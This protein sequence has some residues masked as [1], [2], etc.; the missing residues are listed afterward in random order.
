MKNA[1]N[2]FTEHGTPHLLT[3]SERLAQTTFGHTLAAKGI[4]TAR[5]EDLDAIHEQAEAFAKA[6]F[7]HPF[8]PTTQPQDLLRKHQFEQHHKDL[9]ERAIPASE[10]SDAR[11]REIEHALAHENKGLHKPEVPPL[12]VGFAV[13]MIALT[14]APTL[15]DQFFTTLNDSV[16]A[17][18]ASTMASSVLGAFV[19]WS[20]LG[21][22][23]LGEHRSALNWTGLLA[24]VGI[25]LGLGVLRIAY[26]T[27]SGEYIFAAALTL[28]EISTVV[29]VEFI[30]SGLRSRHH[31]WSEQQS[32]LAPL[33]A[34]LEAAKRNQVHCHTHQQQL[35]QHCHDHI[36]YVEFR[37]LRHDKRDSIHL[38]A[39]AV[40]ESGYR[41]QLAENHRIRTGNHHPNLRRVA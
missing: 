37:Q 35:E 24:G 41:E 27:T 1:T 4:D 12:I 8:D 17:W 13:L 7:T 14:V 16:L 9:H 31:D 29:S 38:H 23:A 20:M 15:H 36:A 25:G 28:V 5:K 22:F 30:A 21:S 10:F 33:L 34:D 18:V 39:K 26:A 32:A 19:V 2:S 3:P 11:V 40:A 6:A